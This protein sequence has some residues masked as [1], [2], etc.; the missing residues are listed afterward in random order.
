VPL[1]RLYDSCD[2]IVARASTGPNPIAA[3]YTATLA[4]LYSH[5][6]KVAGSAT[7]SFLRPDK[8]C[9]SVVRA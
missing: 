6:R 2:P 9:F 4:V 7:A 3:N 1:L 5:A 8:V